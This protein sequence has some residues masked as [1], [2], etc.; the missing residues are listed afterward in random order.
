MLHA[1]IQNRFEA[2]FIAA[3]G[4]PEMLLVDHLHRS[5]ASTLWMRLPDTK[6]L[7]AFQEFYPGDDSEL[8]KRA[9]LLVGHNA[10]FAKSFEYGTERR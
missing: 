2:T 4:P 5:R 6:Y 1:A 10:E 9:I 8:P 7:T 3:G